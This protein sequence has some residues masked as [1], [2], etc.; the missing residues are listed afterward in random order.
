MEFEECQC[1]P[2]EILIFSCSGASNVGQ[3]SNQA[4]IKLTRDNVGKFFC[5]AGL[6]GHV[7]AMVESAKVGRRFVV[8]DGC[9]IA[10]G[11]ETIVHLGYPLTDYVVV[12]ELGIKKRHNF[13][14]DDS[15]IEKVCAAVK[16]KLGRPLPVTGKLD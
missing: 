9:P 16:E 3:I 2:A 5:L 13:D 10:C 4:A 1:T 8:I 14:L 11:K 15:D 12:S 7:P 6:G